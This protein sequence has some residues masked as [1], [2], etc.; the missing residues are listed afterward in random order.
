MLKTTDICSLSC[1]NDKQIFYDEFEKI[2]TNSTTEIKIP[3]KVGEYFINYSPV[4]NYPDKPHVIICGKTTSDKSHELFVKAL[5]NGKSMHEACF[6]SIYANGMRDNLFEY[7]S[8][9]GLFDYLSKI[10]SYWE[11]NDPKT[12]WNGMFENLDNS[13]DS[14]IQLTQAFNCAILHPVKKSAEPPKKV[15][16]NVQNEI[17]CFFKHFRFSNQLKLIIF[18]DTPTKDGRFHQIDFWKND[19]T[20]SNKNVKMISITHPSNQNRIIFNN[21]DD[22]TQMKSNKKE[23]AIR[24][25]NEAKSTIDDLSDELK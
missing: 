16:R 13:L 4:G 8:K 18:L 20:L 5:K 23:N 1:F 12:K 25:F 7:L 14:G 17:G 9:I 22:L 6:S 3:L 2:K 24:I 10:V 15:F 21:L 11:T 19:P